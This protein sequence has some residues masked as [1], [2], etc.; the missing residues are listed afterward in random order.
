MAG[1]NNDAVAIRV[2]KR[3]ESAKRVELHAA[4]QSSEPRAHATSGSSAHSAASNAIDMPLPVKGGI[5]RSA[6]PIH[7]SPALPGW[8]LGYRQ[9][10]AGS[11]IGYITGGVT[12]F[13]VLT[14]DAAMSTETVDSVPRAFMFNAGVGVRF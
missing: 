10:L 7:S 11:E 12:L 13:R 6:S 9:N 8:R 2:R 14:L 3:R 5:I 1:S 4:C